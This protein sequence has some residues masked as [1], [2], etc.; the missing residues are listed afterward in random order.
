MGIAIERLRVCLNLC[1]QRHALWCIEREFGRM[2]NAALAKYVKECRA[3]LS[4]CTREI[5]ESY[6]IAGEEPL[7]L[8]YPQNQ[9][10]ASLVQALCDVAVFCRRRHTILKRGGF[11]FSLSQ[12]AAE[13]FQPLSSAMVDVE[14]SR[15]GLN[16]FLKARNQVYDEVYALITD[17]CRIGRRV[18]YHDKRHRKAYSN[19][20]SRY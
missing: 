9:P 13:T 6:K 4:A 2:R 3:L 14:L 19:S 15:M 17:I 12:K 8:S 16:K 1:A 11:D 7:K 20:R 18:F 5:R 10:R